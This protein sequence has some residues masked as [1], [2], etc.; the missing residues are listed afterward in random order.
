MRT[1]LLTER[2]MRGT[3]RLAVRELVRMGTGLLYRSADSHPKIAIFACAKFV[4]D[5]KE[6]FCIFRMVLFSSL[7]DRV[8]ILRSELRAQSV[9]LFC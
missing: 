6:P 9:R 7:G 4:L 3:K 5:K 2:F 8:G 1:L